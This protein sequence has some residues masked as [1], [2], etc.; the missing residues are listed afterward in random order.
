MSSL[1]VP[2]VNEFKGSKGSSS[3]TI[4][5][6]Q[7]LAISNIL[8]EISLSIFDKDINAISDIWFMRYVDD[9]L[10]LTTDGQAESIASN[11]IEKLQRLNLNPHP[12]N[13]ENSKS[14]AGPLRESFDFLGY[15][16][17]KENC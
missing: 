8:A 3:N 16:I 17:A 12:L 5:V 9:I 11:V 7:G 13:D 4:G 10:I 6:P 15:H 14:K 1:V 2:T